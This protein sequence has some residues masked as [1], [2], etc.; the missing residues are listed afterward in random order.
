[1]GPNGTKVFERSTPA[2]ARL[3]KSL[4]EGPPPGSG[5]SDQALFLSGPRALGPSVDQTV[6]GRADGSCCT[7]AADQLETA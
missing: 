1:M 6:L 4:L 2:T 3:A 5:R 7:V